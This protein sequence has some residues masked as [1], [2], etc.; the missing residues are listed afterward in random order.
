MTIKNNRIESPEVDPRISRQQI[1]DK[2]MK[3]LHW[4]NIPFLNILLEKL[5][6]HPY[7]K[8]K[9]SFHTSHHTQ[10]F[11]SNGS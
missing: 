10:K 8:S 3:A 4:T 1:F 5:I 11:I 7:A 6:A 2:G 9:T